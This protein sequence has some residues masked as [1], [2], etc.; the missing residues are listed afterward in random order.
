[1]HTLT[2]HYANFTFIFFHIK[3]TSQI[4]PILLAQMKL[5]TM[6]NNKNSIKEAH[7][8]LWLCIFIQ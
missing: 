3:N 2:Q 4:F 6:I 1:M 7:K 8:E 5:H